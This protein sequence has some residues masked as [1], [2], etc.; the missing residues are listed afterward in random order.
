MISHAVSITDQTLWV[1]YHHECF[2]PFDYSWS[3]D[4]RGL[5]L[6]YCGVKFGECCGQAEFFADLSDFGLPPSVTL[7]ATL[8]LGVLVDGIQRGIP[9]EQRVGL[10]REQLSK[11]GFTAYQVLESSPLD[12]GMH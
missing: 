6:N 3:L 5:E 11:H 10:V 12:S 9:R 4:L 7:V 2:G 1:M 8:A